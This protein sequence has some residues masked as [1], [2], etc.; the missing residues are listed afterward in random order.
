MKKL[1]KRYFIFIL[2][3]IIVVAATILEQKGNTQKKVNLLGQITTT[4]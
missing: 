1:E 2:L 4:K 3:L